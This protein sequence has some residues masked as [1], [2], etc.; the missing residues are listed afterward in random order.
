MSGEYFCIIEVSILLNII[1]PAKTNIEDCLCDE[2]VKYNNPPS[3]NKSHILIFVS[4]NINNPITNINTHIISIL[5][6]NTNGKCSDIFF[7]LIPC[8][9]FG[10]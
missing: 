5:F 6:I 8:I 7:I 4:V 1:T 2:N 9:V 10:R 3:I